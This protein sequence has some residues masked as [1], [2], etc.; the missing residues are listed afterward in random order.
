M[1]ICDESVMALQCIYSANS[2]TLM[3]NFI[4]EFYLYTQFILPLPYKVLQWEY[5]LGIE[6]KLSHEIEHKY[7]RKVTTVEIRLTTIFHYI[8]ENY[9]NQYIINQFNN[10]KLTN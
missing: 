10:M 6:I 4:L 8:I 3:F 1:Q 7:T 2:T 5:K 9:L